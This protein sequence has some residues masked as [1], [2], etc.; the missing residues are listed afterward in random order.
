MYLLVGDNV[1]AELQ[2]RLRDRGKSEPTHTKE[3]I[4]SPKSVARKPFSVVATSPIDSK[5]VKLTRR[6]IDTNGPNE[7]SSNN[8]YTTTVS[9]KNSI[10]SP[11]KVMFRRVTS[12]ASNNSK[13]LFL[14]V[15][16]YSF[17]Y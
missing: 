12:P 17:C 8:S 13:Q 1:M 10:S 15:C 5:S 7:E 14:F 16:S 6:T 9:V 4:D 11:N 3:N 2:N